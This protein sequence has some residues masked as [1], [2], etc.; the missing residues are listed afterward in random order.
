MFNRETHSLWNQYTGE[1]VVGPLVASGLALKQRP[2]V[3]T[4]WQRWN[5]SNPSTK[6][7]SLSTRHRRDYGP[8]VVYYD[9]FASPDLMFPAV[10]D[11]RAHRQ[12]DYVFTIRQFG[13]ARAW[14]LD[15]F[16]HRPM[17][18]DAIGDTKI[19]MIGD[20]QTH[21]LRAYERGGQT[22]ATK[23]GRLNSQT[24]A[25]WRVSED[26]LLGPDGIRL[27]RIAGHISCR[28]AWDKYLGD[29]ASVVGG[30]ARSG[31]IPIDSPDL[32]LTSRRPRLLYPE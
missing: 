7:L 23:G 19:V 8:A 1:P 4:T 31:L 10:V 6:A 13:L 12:Q 25:E 17:I 18:N 32:V 20:A 9:Y 15:S 11:Q 27:P 2:V 16:D 21:N 28:F 5:A 14:P 26:A 29:S 3:I 24:G 30:S 22:F